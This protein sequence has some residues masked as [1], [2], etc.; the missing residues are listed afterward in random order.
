MAGRPKE[1]GRQRVAVRGARK[2][3]LSGG[4]FALT[5]GR[6]HQCDGHYAATDAVF[7]DAR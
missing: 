3:L 5:M 2:P 7:R 4:D 6:R 1:I